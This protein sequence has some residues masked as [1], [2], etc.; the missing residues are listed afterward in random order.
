M[1]EA[2]PQSVVVVM[3][4]SSLLLIMAVAIWLLRRQLDLSR[5]RLSELQAKL[6]ERA[7]EVEVEMGSERPDE[8]VD[9]AG[10]VA[11]SGEFQ[12]HLELQWRRTARSRL[13]MSLLMIGVDGLAESGGSTDSAATN[14]DL[15]HIPDV[16]A[17]QLHRP[18]DMAARLEDGVFAVLLPET[19]SSGGIAVAER[20]REVVADLQLDRV[21]GTS[22]RVTVSVGVATTIPTPQEQSESL[23]AAADHALSVATSKGGDR[24]ES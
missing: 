11:G 10:V 5:E 23:V 18:G 3:M 7:H 8:A 17:R 21:A 20:L 24:V 9:G 15:G 12:R 22:R 16:V 6:E 19:D 4:A 14:L 2:S 13:P 1:M